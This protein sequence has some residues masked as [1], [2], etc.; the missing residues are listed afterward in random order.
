[1]IGAWSRFLE[2][3]PDVEIAAAAEEVEPEVRQACARV[4]PRIRILRD[5]GGAAARR[6]N[7]RWRPR[8]YALDES[9]RLVYVQAEETL[10][11][12]APAELRRLWFGEH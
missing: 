2:Q 8:V 12:Q 11:G 7:A 6:F 10:D 4:D 3:H 5:R 1:M 9:G